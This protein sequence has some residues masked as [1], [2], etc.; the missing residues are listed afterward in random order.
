MRCPPNVKPPQGG[1]FVG[2]IKMI[3]V[4]KYFNQN[5]GWADLE[6]EYEEEYYGENPVR[7]FSDGPYVMIGEGCF[8]RLAVDGSE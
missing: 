2:I 8:Y 4:D 5:I 3:P 6:D 1:F 7:V